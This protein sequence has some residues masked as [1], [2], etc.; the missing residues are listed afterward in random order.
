M[1]LEAVSEFMAIIN[2]SDEDFNKIL[3]A[4]DNADGAAGRMA[5]TMNDNAQGALKS[6]QSAVEDVSI[7][8]SNVFLESVSFTRLP[9]KTYF[10]F[11]AFHYGVISRIS[12]DRY[13]RVCHRI[14][15]SIQFPDFGICAGSC[16]NLCWHWR[17][18]F[19][20]KPLGR[21][22]EVDRAGHRIHEGLAQLA[23]AWENVQPFIEALM[24]LLEKI[25]TLIGGVIVGA[26]SLLFR[27]ASWVFM[28]IA[29][30]INWVTDLL[31]GFAGA[32]QWVSDL[33]GG[34]I[35]KA[36]N[37]IGLKNEITGVNTAVTQGI[38]ERTLAGSST[39]TQSQSNTFNL[40]NPNQFAAASASAQ[41]F[42]GYS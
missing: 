12:I 34:L 20:E 8:M 40:T 22:S 26:I 33:L 18:R 4:V 3:A 5:A 25:A 35:D 30:F 38:A 14:C 28:Q 9:A 42:F 36:M 24:P 32:I 41:T 2:A 16:H 27:V 11:C 1:G 23:S 17:Y 10:H 7:D 13:E 15:H 29:G 39:T 21:R 6:L 19:A 37:F 31:S